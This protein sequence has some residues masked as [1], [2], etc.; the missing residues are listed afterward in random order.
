MT[1]EKEEIYFMTVNIFNL[2]LSLY[3]HVTYGILI[4]TIVP[5]SGSS[6]FCAAW[7]QSRHGAVESILPSTCLSTAL[8]L[9]S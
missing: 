4:P 3:H 9:P 8:L 1:L 2:W 5:F 6:H 7:I